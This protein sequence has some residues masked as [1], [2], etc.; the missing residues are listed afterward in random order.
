VRRPF[1]HVAVHPAADQDLDEQ[2]D[3]LSRD[4]LEVALRFLSA[5]EQTFRELAQMPGIGAPK[6][7]RNPQLAG[8][9]QWRIRGFE[10]HLIFYRETQ[11]GI[12]VIRVLHG[13]RDVESI[14]E[15]ET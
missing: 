10:R 11:D 3:D 2:F 4:S 7:F 14:L 1:P 6:K 8:V 12:E 5:A 9:R 15:R 13:A